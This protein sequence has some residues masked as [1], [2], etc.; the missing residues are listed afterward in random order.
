MLK[1]YVNIHIDLSSMN[2]TSKTAKKSHN[3]RE[4]QIKSNAQTITHIPQTHNFYH[5]LIQT[6]QLI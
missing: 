4:I 2:K 5:Y 1:K 3:H 6:K